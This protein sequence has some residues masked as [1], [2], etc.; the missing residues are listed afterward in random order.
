MG[1]VKLVFFMLYTFL[2]QLAFSSSLPHLCPKDQALTLLQFKDMF[3]INP[4]ASD[5][6]FKFKE[7]HSYPKTLTWNKSTDCC[8]WDGVHCDKTTG[9]VIEL[10]ITCSGLQGKF[11]SNSSLFQLSNLRRLDLSFNNFS[12]SLISP[13]F[14]DFSNL[15][16]LDLTVTSFSGQIPSEIS[17]LSKLHDLRISNVYPYGLRFGPHN[18]ESL[19]KNL[20]Q[21][22]ELHLYDVNISSTIPSNFSSHLTTIQLS[23][24]HLRG[25]LPERVFHLSNLKTLNLSDNPKLT[26]R[27]PITNWNSSASLMELFLHGVNITGKIPESFSHLTA[28]HELDMGYSNLAGPIPKPLWNLTHVE[29]LSLRYNHLEGPIS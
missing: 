19:L 25:I 1:Y 7:F 4:N 16:Y 21:L 26:V 18:F 10:N 28:L 23:L 11:H 14:G 12:G 22:K 27:F 3:P 6:C 29:W 8:S 20:T 24:T 15:T 5:Y 13:K 9:Q 2:C 17:H